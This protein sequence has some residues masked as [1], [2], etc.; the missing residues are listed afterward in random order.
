LNLKEPFVRIADYRPSDEVR[1]LV[2]DLD[3]WL[4]LL[5]KVEKPFA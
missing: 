4:G 3:E 1:D 2:A 5:S